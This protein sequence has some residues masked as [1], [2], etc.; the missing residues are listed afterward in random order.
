MSSILLFLLVLGVLI[1]VHELGHFVA[2]KACGIYVD[3]FSLGMPPRIFGFK[4][5]ETDYCIGALPIGGYVK[6]A[7]QEDS[8][9]S[10]EE[11]EQ[12]YG[13]VPPERW[14]NK[15]PRWQRA[16]VLVAGPFMNLV[17]AFVVYA[18]IAAYGAEV[19]M[20]E[21]EARL[22]VIAE[23]SAASKAPLYLANDPS[24][25]I[26]LTAE[27]DAVGWRTGDK[28]LHIDDT[29]IGRFRDLFMEAALGGGDAVVVEIERPNAEGGVTRYLSPITP[30]FDEKME[31]SKFGVGP[32]SPALIGVVFPGTPAH[33]QGV[34]NGDTIIRAAERPVDKLSL[35]L[36]LAELPAGASV[37][38]EIDR[39]GE[40]LHKSLETKVSGS[41]KGIGFVPSIA[42]MASVVTEVS[43]PIVMEDSAFTNATGL[44]KDD[45]VVALDGDVNVGERFYSLVRG[46][47]PE[48]VS[49]KVE[50]PS[51]G[52]GLFQA[53]SAQTLTVPFELVIAGVTGA[54]KD[55]HP[56]V[57]GITDAAREGTDLKR[58][59]I[60]EEID[61]Q[62]ATAALLYKT[63][64]ER[65]G[66]T[67]PVKVRRPAL[68]W[69]LLR[70]EKTFD[71][72]LTVASVQ[73]IGILWG[74]KTVQLQATPGQIVPWAIRLSIS[75]VSTVWKT[76]K[77]LFGGTLSPKQLGG[78][79]LIFQ[80]T[81]A[82]S[83]S[84]MYSLLTLVAFISINL[85]M[86]NLLPLPVLD[87]GQ[88]LF[89]G[90]EAVRRKPVSLRVMELVQ[91][92]GVLLL[93]GLMVYVT[94]N[95]IMRVVQGWLS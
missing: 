17:L 26:D 62:P 90:I 86:L 92:A 24:A 7:G 53:A 58:K 61:G 57:G 39:D 88:L 50:R 83:E 40:I 55:A 68:A 31:I 67:I 3:R 44:K 94:F 6:M 63:Q 73:Q 25:T 84:G 4:W 76:L 14:F 85:C 34:Q 49:L 60:I 29:A 22:G 74:E 2:A 69:G 9:L 27:P 54:T 82:A 12:T 33:A 71:T 56:I 75:D 51:K 8:P 93:I 91:T 95:D 19:P 15:K 89:L 79:V 52:F 35:M 11:R 5:G 66:E 16:I 45:L 18:V 77:G 23:D 32:F 36:M 10:D 59:D 65:I 64:N 48:S 1:F 28:I 87:G 41:I 80:A 37:E 30:E 43:L 81:T 47:W 21:T 38:L 13:H 42:R 70:G 20:S 78:P 46:D 72:E